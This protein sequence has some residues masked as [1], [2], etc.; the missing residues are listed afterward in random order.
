M[1]QMLKAERNLLLGRKAADLLGDISDFERA[2]AEQ[3]EVIG[4]EA[5]AAQAYL[6]SGNG[7]GLVVSTL[8][9]S[10]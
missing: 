6:P 9:G 3:R 10:R 1:C 7:T 4:P 5:Q 2:H 8:A